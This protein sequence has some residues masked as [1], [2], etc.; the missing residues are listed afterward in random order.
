MFDLIKA[1]IP[2]FIALVLI[3]AIAYH[4]D[5][6][7]DQPGYDARD[8]ATSLTM[9]VG[10]VVMNLGWKLVMIA[11]LAAVY[12]V[13]P[14]HMPMDQ[15]WPWALLI[16]AEDLCFY[17][18]HRSGHEIR[19]L[20]AS[21][22]VHHSS[23]H[24]NLSTALRQEWFH[25]YTVV[26]WV[27]L[28]IV[29][30]PPYAIVLAQ[31]ISLVYQFWI[32]TEKIR[33]LPRPI[34]F[35]FNTPSHHRVHH[36]ANTGYLDRNY[37]GILIIWDRMFG[38]FREENER[39][40]YGL[41]KNVESFNPIRVVTHEWAMIVSDL[42]SAPDFRTKLGYLFRKPGWEPNSELEETAAEEIQAESPEVKTPV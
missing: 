21:H 27:P 16:V 39:V 15:P 30:F 2:F 19:L 36:G 7:E 9:G 34:E 6:H 4:F 33:K 32:H 31:A 1:A 5:D 18:S 22:V 20:W 8:T 13:V 24:Y 42:K 28:A 41:T 10:N 17:A 35:L 37:G 29:G 38:T 40:V 14:F 25:M 26:F 12:S 23:Q 3:E 11:V